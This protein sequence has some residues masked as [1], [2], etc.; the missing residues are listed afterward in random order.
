MNVFKKTLLTTVIAMGAG[1]AYSAETLRFAHVYETSEP[2][3]KWALWAADEIKARTDGRYEIEVF[4]ASS[5]G[6]E[7][8]INEGLQLGTVDIIYTGTGFASRLYPPMGVAGGAYMFRDFDHWKAFSESDYFQELSDGFANETGNVLLALNYYGARH[9]TSNKPIT[10]PEDMK[11]LRIRVPN[12]PLYMAFPKSVDANP[13]PLAFDEVYLALQQGVVDAQENP[14]P[15]I[16]AKAFYEVQS[17]INL[18]GHIYDSLI[19]V[20]GGPRWSQLSDEDREI[21]RDV[22]REAARNNTEETLQ[23]EADLVE[24]F[25]EQGNNVNETDRPA[26]REAAIK[27]QLDNPTTWDKATFERIQEIGQ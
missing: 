18:T 12:A 11:N 3:H 14:L 10:K 6:K 7:A 21:F 19:T 24:W 27:Y 17:D 23:A 9:V 25:K 4:P 8:D 13:T 26:F 15:T 2:F 1:A 22:F 20:I 5:L 16:K